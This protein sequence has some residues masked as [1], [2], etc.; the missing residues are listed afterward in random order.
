MRGKTIPVTPD[1]IVERARSQCGLGINYLLG[2]GG[3][4]PETVNCGTSGT[5]ADCVGLALWAAGVDRLQRGLDLGDYDGWINCNSILRLRKPNTL[6]L[7]VGCTP[8]VSVQPGDIAVRPGTPTN[9]HG[10]MV[11]CVGTNRAVH[12]SK[13]NYD[14]HSTPGAIDETLIWSYRG[15]RGAFKAGTRLHVF[16]RIQVKP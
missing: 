11:V 15:D 16:R 2:E 9:R 3:K 1:Q 5:Y 8:R 4:D 12:C 10:H 6:F 13:S 14:I 7:Y